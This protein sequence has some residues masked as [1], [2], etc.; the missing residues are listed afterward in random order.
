[1]SLLETRD[2]VFVA[3]RF[4]A[5]AIK[6]GFIE[7]QDVPAGDYESALKAESQAIT[8]RLAP[9]PIGQGHVLGENRLL[10]IRDPKPLQNRRRR[11]RQG[12]RPHPPRKRLEGCPRP[13]R[14]RPLRAGLRP[15]RAP[16]TAP[17]LS[18]SGTT[19]PKTEA[20]YV[21]GRDIGDEYRYVLE[22]KYAKKYPGNMLARP[23]LLLQPWAIAQATTER[24]EAVRARSS[25]ASR[26]RGRA[27][28]LA[29]AQ[30]RRPLLRRAGALANLDFLGE[31]AVLLANLRPDEK[32]VVTIPH[33]DLG[34]H[35]QIRVLAVDSANTVYRE[36]SLPEADMK[37]L[38]LRLAAGLDPTSTSSSRSRPTSSAKAR[39]S[40]LP[41]SPPRPSR[42]TT[43]S[44]RSTASMPP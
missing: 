26:R 21:A 15:V 33:K 18:P 12:L 25:S 5:L 3:D 10:Q 14:R 36:V 1:M 35:Q 27:R 11:G 28:R 43:R 22:R 29:A 4:D 40:S 2:G 24:Q 19:L 44:P 38:D 8:I 7:I 30:G 13:R 17:E 9:G 31:P 16:W 32:G 41:T 34:A 6:D 42:P 37:F 39:I 23:S 20:L